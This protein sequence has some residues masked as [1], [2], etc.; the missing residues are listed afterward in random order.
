LIYSSNYFRKVLIS[1]TVEN[2]WMDGWITAC[3]LIGCN[4]SSA[5]VTC[6]GALK[7]TLLNSSL[8]VVVKGFN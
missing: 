6:L 8:L 4:S 3:S 1:E 5:F 7:V 2:G